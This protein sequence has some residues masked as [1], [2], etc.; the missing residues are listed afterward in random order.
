MIDARLLKE[1]LQQYDLGALLQCTP[2]LGGTVNTNYLLHTQKGKWV[3]T[4]LESMPNALAQKISQFLLFLNHH[5][6]LTP[7]VQLTLSKNTIVSF[8]DKPSIIVTYINGSSPLYPSQ[9]QCYQ[10]GSTLAQ[11]HQLTQS[12]VCHLPNTMNNEWREKTVP[13][14]MPYCTVKE[15]DL[16]QATLQ[17]QAHLPYTALPHG[18]VHFDLFKDNSLFIG[19]RLQGI[20][21]FYYACYDTL[22][23]DVC[24]CI[25][26]WCTNWQDPKRAI[27]P[28]N[29]TALQK[30]YELVRPLT[31]IEHKTLPSMLKISALH[32]WLARSQSLKKDPNDYKQIFMNQFFN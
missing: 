20:I 30:G 10:I 27:I 11:L 12:Y 23:I 22:L 25:H 1:H 31:K 29:L 17:E 9:Q 15:Q 18:I 7:I 8:Q 32:F 26:D 4:I 21:D 16:I 24:I 13:L 3:F 28:E 5:Q 2:L 19:N 14:L 6:F